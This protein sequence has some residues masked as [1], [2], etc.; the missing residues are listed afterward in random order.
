MA[1]PK[2]LQCLD[3]MVSVFTRWASRFH[4]TVMH[5]QKHQHIDRAVAI[6]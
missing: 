1:L 3:V 2:L 4:T 6:V 5:D